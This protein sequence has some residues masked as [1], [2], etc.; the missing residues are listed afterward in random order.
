MKAGPVGAGAVRRRISE[1]GRGKV[2][3]QV[4]LELAVVIPLTE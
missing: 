4:G 3:P 2:R 1:A